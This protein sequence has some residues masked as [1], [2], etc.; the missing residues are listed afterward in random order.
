MEHA[1][2]LAIVGSGEYMPAMQE[3]EA[4]LLEGREQRTATDR[5]GTPRYVQ[6]ATAAAPEGDRVLSRWH[7]LGAQAAERLC[8]QQVIV[9]V[10]TR[11][12][13]DDDAHADAIAGA[14]L[15]YL[16][17]GNPVHL[18]RTLRGTRVWQAIVDEWRAGAALASA[19]PARAP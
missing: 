1:G 5:S 18:A 7:D 8:A 2:R 12:D 15:I 11:S 9:D 13:A 16:S 3:I 6:L 14:S 17:G 4:W 19:E 10:R